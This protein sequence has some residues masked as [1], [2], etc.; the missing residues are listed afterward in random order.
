MPVLAYRIL[1]REA[2]I[3]RLEQY[4]EQDPIVLGLVGAKAPVSECRFGPKTRES[5][6]TW[7]P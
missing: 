2:Q 4:Y 3:V 6:L 7:R 1:Y 5:C